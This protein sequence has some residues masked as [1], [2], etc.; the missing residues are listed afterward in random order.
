MVYHLL[1]IPA[2]ALIKV[3]LAYLIVF[4]VIFA[5]TKDRL[6]GR[7]NGCKVGGSQ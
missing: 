6:Y 3:L 5:L 2:A 7:D 4:S 1:L